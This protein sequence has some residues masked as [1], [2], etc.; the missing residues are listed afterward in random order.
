M[1]FRSSPK[2]STD[3]TGTEFRVSEVDPPKTLRRRPKDELKEWTRT[4]VMAF[5]MGL[6]EPVLDSAQLDPIHAE[7]IL[8]DKLDV[9]EPASS[10]S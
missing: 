8:S 6:T 10:G 4:G 2:E 7:S 5:L 9:H 1:L 3:L